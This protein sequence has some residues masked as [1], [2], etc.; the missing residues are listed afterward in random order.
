[1][2]NQKFLSLAVSALVAVSGV[3]GCLAVP[4]FCTSAESK[5]LTFEMTNIDYNP[6]DSV[7]YVDVFVTQIPDG[8]EVYAM[9]GSIS[10]DASALELV[11]VP[12]DSCYGLVVTNESESCLRWSIETND[13]NMMPLEAK[14]GD[15][16]IY[17]G[18]KVK[19]TANNGVYQIKWDRDYTMASSLENLLF[20][21]SLPLTITDGSIT[22]NR[23]TTTTTLPETTTTTTTTVPATTT[24]TTTTLPET[25]TTTTT[26]VPATTT[27]TTTT[28]PATTTT[29]TTTVPA[30]TT[31][32][33]TTLPETTTTTTTTLPETT[34][35]TT[36][37]VPVTTTT[38]T[39]TV[40]A[41][42]TTTTTT[43]PA[44]TTTTTTTVPATTTTT[45]IPA[46]TTTTT[47]T[48]PATTTTTTTT[49]PATT[50]TTTTTI[51]ATTTT[52][53]ATTLPKPSLAGDANC[54]KTVDIADVVLIKCYIINPNEYKLS[55]QG[56]ANADVHGSSNGL[57]AQDAVAIAKH[58]LHVIP[59]LSE[60]K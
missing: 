4:A 45:T 53:P 1:M 21:G 2:K 60:L 29:T 32:T 15:T 30:T 9:Q 54:D 47:T 31:T 35:T 58:I 38:T 23:S 52:T 8:T 3:S 27:T 6:N 50:T 24:T 14:E 26:T 19:D 48:V 56:F 44:T 28:I 49:V 25:T 33:T 11:E 17:F 41:T 59:S 46:T 51:P 39:T 43:V 7:Q 34:T 13:P 55:A 37:T 40:P 16:V 18:F 57:N 20:G 10:Y 42:T 12:A 5:T 36:T 22:V